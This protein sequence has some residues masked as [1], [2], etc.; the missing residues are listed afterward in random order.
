MKLDLV[1]VDDSNLWLSLAK[2]LAESHP[3]VGRIETFN[4]SIDAWVYLQLTRPDL[5][6]TDIEMPGMNGL[7]FLEMFGDK[8]PIISS[9]TKQGYAMH[10]KELGCIDFLQKP[11][12]RKIFN[13]AIS[14]AHAKCY[15][16]STAKKRKKFS[17]NLW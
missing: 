7:S 16:R 13:K 9:S 6:M 1:I 11:F 10:A 2:K 3:L 12:T 5:V 17:A 14:E 15:S 8:L 4:D